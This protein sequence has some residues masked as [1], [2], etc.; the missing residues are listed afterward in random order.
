MQISFVPH[1]EAP[2]NFRS[3]PFTRK[4]W[5]MLLGYP[6][7]FKDST[8]ITQAFAPFAHVLHWN[9]DDAS[10]VR[11]ILKVLV[12]DP[13]EIPRSLV[14]KMGREADGN[15]RSWTVPVYVFNSDLVN[16]GPT[17]EKDPPAHNGNPHPLHGPVVPGEE[18]FVAQMADHFVE[19]FPPVNQMQASD[20][21]STVVGPLDSNFS[22]GANQEIEVILPEEMT[23]QQEAQ[24]A[25]LQQEFQGE[26]GKVMDNQ[27]QIFQSM[28]S[29]PEQEK[30]V[31]IFPQLQP[32]VSQFCKLLSSFSFQITPVNNMEGNACFKLTGLGGHEM[33]MF[34]SN[35]K[36]EAYNQLLLPDPREPERIV[37]MNEQVISKVYFRK[38][39]KVRKEPPTETARIFTPVSPDYQLSEEPKNQS[40]KQTP[41]KKRKATPVSKTSLRRS[42]RGS[43]ASQG[44]KP[45]SPASTRSS[46]NKV[47]KCLP[48][49]GKSTHF[50]IP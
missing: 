49:A 12:E 34:V 28:T 15:G 48:L 18:E 39:W 1:D 13:L 10:T 6:L 36:H 30:S 47:S 20:Q 32:L 43:A 22:Q 42:K 33:N 35:T 45:S 9:S 46:R 19:N 37:T 5:I 3:V 29:A 24:S 21:D 25:Q 2:M 11:F 8:I 16:A 38:R 40:T 44:F 27:A 26:Q 4:S 7:D 41:T 31:E 23:Q 14:M 17:Y 50:I